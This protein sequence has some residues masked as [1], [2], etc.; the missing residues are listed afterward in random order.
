M[1]ASRGGNLE[2]AKLLLERGADVNAETEFT[3]GRTTAL[4]AASYS[5]HEAN[6]RTV[7]RKRRRCQ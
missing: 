4:K 1:S 2:V 6:C 5:G 3:E 7:D